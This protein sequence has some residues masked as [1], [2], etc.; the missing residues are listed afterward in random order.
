[1]KPGQA[2]AKTVSP[3]RW[4]LPLGVW[5]AA[6]AGGQ[7]SAAETAEGSVAAPAPAAASVGYSIGFHLGSLMHTIKRLGLEPDENAVRAGLTDA[8]TGA[9]PPLTAA[10]AA[11][12]LAMIAHRAGQPGSA[13]SRSFDAATTRAFNG[14]H[15]G[16]EG[17]VTLPN[18]LQYHVERP[19]S[20]RH[21][22]PD[23]ALTMHYQ[24][25]LPNGVVLEDSFAE[26]EPVT[27]RLAEIAS[28][29]LRQALGLMTE[30]AEWEVFV[31]PALAFPELSTLRDRAAIYRVELIRVI[32]AGD[33]QA[34]PGNPSPAPA[35]AEP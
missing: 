25:T 23:D 17:V 13:A 29:G 22:Q 1:M 4:S 6:V 35:Q 19:G 20:G 10:E 31:P 24:A 21:P 8:L 2:R 26:G 15:A 30:G 33:G 11:Q 14:L 18:G 9:S 32:P 27:L 12:L 3:S 28:P 7:A 34:L 5:L 16:R